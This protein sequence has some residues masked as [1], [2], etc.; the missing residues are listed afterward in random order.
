MRT[1]SANLQTLLAQNA[2][3]TVHLL[4]FAVGATAYRFAEDQVFHQ[5]NL[6]L[7]RLTLLSPVRL[8]NRLAVEPVTVALENITLQTAALLRAEQDALQGAEAALS[9]L[10]LQASEALTLFVGR[11]G[12]IQIDEQRATLTLQGELDPTATQVPRRKYSSLCVW[13]F[14]DAN[15]GYTDGVDPDDPA[16]G[17][18]FVTCPKD[19]LSCVARSREERFP[20]FLHITRDLTE[21][22]EG[23]RGI[24][25]DDRLLGRFDDED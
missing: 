3:S 2:S 6:Y 11:I 25:E 24:E 15:C 22:V 10:F 19:F 16:T 13:D 9:R 12:E 7:P 14:K 8:S 21:S 18:P 20:G 5:G 4:S 1:L 17:Q 23:Q